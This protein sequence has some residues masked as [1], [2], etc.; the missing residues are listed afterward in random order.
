MYT[1]LSEQAVLM[2]RLISL[3]VGLT[4]GAM[5][6]DLMKLKGPEDDTMKG[7]TI[8]GCGLI[9]FA[10]YQLIFPYLLLLTVLGCGQVALHFYLRKQVWMGDSAR[11]SSN[12][13]LEDRN[14]LHHHDLD[15]SDDES[16]FNFSDHFGND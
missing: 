1:E 11:R 15:W 8:L 7:F 9:G 12:P 13:L 5:L 6:C 4:I 3:I 10:F 2:A 14:N 16:D